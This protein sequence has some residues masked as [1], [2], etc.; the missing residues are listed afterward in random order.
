M[1][2]SQADSADRT[3]GPTLLPGDLWAILWRG[4]L[5][6]LASL[7]IGIGWGF[8][9]LPPG[10]LAT[11]SQIEVAILPVPD[12][13]VI[14]A[15]DPWETLLRSAELEAPQGSDSDP[16]IAIV[17]ASDRLTVTLTSVGDASAAHHQVIDRLQKSLGPASG[18]FLGL[19]GAQADADAGAE[20][21]YLLEAR[22]RP[23]GVYGLSVQTSEVT[24]R[25]VPAIHAQFVLV[26]LG[27]GIA[28]TFVLH[29]LGAARRRRIAGPSEN[30]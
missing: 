26:A 25:G 24:P 28:A 3:I 12:A 2:D 11:R 6:L 8:L 27:A 5:L 7:L 16:H 20:A 9:V 23:G 22:T 4:R 15:L 30:R 18:A 21:Q 29:L 13:Q 17:Q 14:G 1:T 19:I 10:A